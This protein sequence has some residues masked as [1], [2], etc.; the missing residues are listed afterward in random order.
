MGQIFHSINNVYLIVRRYN[1]IAPG[2]RFKAYPNISED[3]RGS[4]KQFADQL[5]GILQET[6]HAL[7]D[8]SRVEKKTNLSPPEL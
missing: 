8:L 7:Q 1:E 6:T 2:R 4:A 5:V 3:F